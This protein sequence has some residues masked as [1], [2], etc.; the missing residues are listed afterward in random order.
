[1]LYPTVLTQS[2]SL[3]FLGL[4]YAW[5]LN[6]NLSKSAL[7]LGLRTM[8]IISAILL[9]VQFSLQFD[10]LLGQIDPKY[11]RWLVLSGADT[12]ILAEPFYTLSDQ[13][14]WLTRASFIER[15][16]ACC[17]AQVYFASRD[18]NRGNAELEKLKDHKS[19]ALSRTTKSLSTRE[20][21]FSIW[22]YLGESGVYMLAR[23]ACFLQTYIMHDFQ[24]LV[25]LLWLLVTMCESNPR[26]F[27]R[28]TS[29]VWLPLMIVTFIWYMGINLFGLFDWA[30]F[31]PQNP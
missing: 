12:L 26:V 30:S 16:L 8:Q 21:D 17:L 2:F 18:V 9:L 6:V 20:Q 24:S 22:A 10:Y 15:G 25:F 7:D 3:Y 14:K 4:T 23:L 1:M 13:E 19:T 11:Y 29:F 5:S 28:L 27:V 31:L